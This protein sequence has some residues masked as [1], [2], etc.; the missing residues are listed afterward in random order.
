MTD[1][2]RRKTFQNVTDLVNFHNPDTK[3][4]N[5]TQIL[6]KSNYIGI[7]NKTLSQIISQKDPAQ[8][9]AD[10]DTRVAQKLSL[11][12]DDYLFFQVSTN[13]KQGPLSLYIKPP[14]DVKCNYILYMSTSY[15]H[16]TTDRGFDRKWLNASFLT[17]KAS[18]NGAFQWDKI[19]FSI[20][21]DTAL[22]LTINFR[23]AKKLTQN[24]RSQNLNTTNINFSRKTGDPTDD[25]FKT[26]EEKIMNVS[27]NPYLHFF[28]KN[29]KILA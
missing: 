18:K 12:S 17:I 6:K 23:F 22:P 19:Y 20:F 5:F 25:V 21:S 7:M 10:I 15:K 8:E 14:T 29:K 24:D 27:G 13:K 2:D 3:Y 9:C 4:Q 1:Y 16:P 28:L 11:K 26:F